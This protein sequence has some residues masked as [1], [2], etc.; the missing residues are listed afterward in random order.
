MNTKP[1]HYN[2]SSTTFFKMAS[3]RKQGHGLITVRSSTIGYMPKKPR[4]LFRI[5]T[6][7]ENLGISIYHSHNSLRRSSR[8]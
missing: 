1:W 5:T 3:N 2:K 7:I 4:A 6:N 8:E